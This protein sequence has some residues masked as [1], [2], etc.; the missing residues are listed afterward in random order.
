MYTISTAP[1]GDNR[2]AA[3]IPDALAVLADQLGTGLPHGQVE[4]SITDPTGGEHAG[5]CTL[6]GNLDQL[7]IAVDQL[8]DELY[9]ELHRAAD[10]GPH[11]SRSLQPH[12]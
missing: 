1:G 5:Y 2:T 12:P 6:D 4:W 11:A 8:L 10:G 3:T 7:T 9:T